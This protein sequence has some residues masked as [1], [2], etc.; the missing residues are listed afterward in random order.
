MRIK[1]FIIVGF[2]SFVLFSCSNSSEQIENVVESK[3]IKTDEEYLLEGKTIAENTFKA[4]SGQLKQAI[5][6]GG[7]PNAL[8]FCNV[9][10]IPLTDYLSENYNV[11]IKRVSDKARNPINMPN[12]NEQK[13]IDDYLADAENRKP[14]L[15]KSEEGQVVFY[16]PILTKE[17][18]LNCHGKVGETLLTD[19]HEIIKV[20][21][22]N[23]QAIGY[24]VDEFRGIWSIMF[25]EK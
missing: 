9:N 6:E 24:N 18:C 22:P 15:V 5:A 10:A 20:L 2:L 16:A 19:N 21:Y 25:K 4:L 12:E 14:V 23:D 3:Q 1:G 17:L 11:F 7:I 8:S 13:I